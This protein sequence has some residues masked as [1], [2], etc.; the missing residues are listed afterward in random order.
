[1]IAL[2]GATNEI[3]LTN[4]FLP[5]DVLLQLNISHLLHMGARACVRRI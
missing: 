2:I 4:T 3:Y 1:M 5:S